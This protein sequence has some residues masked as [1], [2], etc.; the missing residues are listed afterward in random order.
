MA[1]LSGALELLTYSVNEQLLVKQ[2]LSS[3]YHKIVIY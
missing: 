3:F 1:T 2:E